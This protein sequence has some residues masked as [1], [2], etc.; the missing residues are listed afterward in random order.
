MGEESE[1]Y[2]GEQS[3]RQALSQDAGHNRNQGGGGAALN[4]AE[5]WGGYGLDSGSVVMAVA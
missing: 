4:V 2:L 5:G 3:E 1:T